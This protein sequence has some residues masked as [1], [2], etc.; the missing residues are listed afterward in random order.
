MKTVRTMLAAAVVVMVAP[1]ASLSAAD[2]SRPLPGDEYLIG[3]T[4]RGYVLEGQWLS[5]S[6]QRR[7]GDYGQGIQIGSEIYPP[8]VAV[9][10]T[11]EVI[12][13]DTGL[14]SERVSLASG[15]PGPD[16]VVEVVASQHPTMPHRQVATLTLHPWNGAPRVVATV[17]GSADSPGSHVSPGKF[18]ILGSVV[19]LRTGSVVALM[20]EN[21]WNLLNFLAWDD[22]VTFTLDGS[23][24]SQPVWGRGEWQ[25]TWDWIAPAPTCGDFY[26]GG[27][28]L[29]NSRL[30]GPTGTFGSSQDGY[31]WAGEAGGVLDFGYRNMQVVFA[32]DGEA[33]THLDGVV[34]RLTPQSTMQ[35][36]APLSSPTPEPTPSKK[37]TTAPSP[38]PSVKPTTT[39]SVK[40]S[41]KPTVPPVHSPTPPPA[42]ATPSFDLYTTPGEHQVNGRRW[43]TR[44]E[45]YSTVERCFT[46]I[47]ASVVTHEGAKFVPTN[48]WVFNNLTYTK[49]PRTLWD[50]NPLGSTGSWT[51]ADGRMWR[52]ECDTP[53]TGKGG[54]RSFIQADVVEAVRSS[55]GT[56]YQWN[57]S[58]W[59]FNNMV[60]FNQ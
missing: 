30:R 11:V 49:G 31:Y 29:D 25:C 60:R 39:P 2:V 5:A 38:K 4:S 59:V 37:P 18:L 47:W 44:C 7:S 42:D 58:V 17:E 34:W 40:P 57:R 9:G 13:I 48:G 41:S 3:A 8:A 15:T 1:I 27:D 19:D 46:E 26:G 14:V 22:H 16:G 21:H 54:C 33:Y 23:D 45:P 28:A 20:A 36:V 55:S 53:L 56:T 32:P 52:T 50:G 51:A 6:D 35:R 24:P 12:D 10:E 43:R